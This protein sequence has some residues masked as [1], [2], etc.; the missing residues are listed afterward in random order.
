MS[1]GFINPFTAL[2]CAVTVLERSN[3]L[4]ARILLCLFQQ[5]TPED[6]MFSKTRKNEEQNSLSSG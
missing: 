3:V 5:P 6:T 4:Q 2:W 1:G